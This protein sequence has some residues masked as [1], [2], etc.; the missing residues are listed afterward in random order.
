M[1]PP[2]TTSPKKYGFILIDRVKEIN[3]SSA[4]HGPQVILW[5]SH[6][7]QCAVFKIYRT[8]SRRQQE[9][10]PEE[11]KKEDLIAFPKLE[12]NWDLKIW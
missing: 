1:Q 3:I 6:Q 11:K 4:T 7:T 2:P 8:E 5:I 10:E 12:L 9:T